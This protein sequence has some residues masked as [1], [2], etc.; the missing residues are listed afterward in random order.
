MHLAIVLGWSKLVDEIIL[1]SISLEQKDTCGRTPCMLAA[2]M[3]H[4]DILRM[5]L[6][7]NAHIN[8][9]DSD[10]KTALMYAVQSYLRYHDYHGCE[11]CMNLLLERNADVNIVDSKGHNAILGQFR[12]WKKPGKDKVL[13]ALINAGCSIS[14]K[15]RPG[16]APLHMAVA[17]LS[18]DL[19]DSFI[20]LGADV[21]QVTGDNKS[22]LCELSRLTS[23]NMPYDKN[24]STEVAKCLLGYGADPDITHP[25][26]V[27]VVY[28][29]LGIVETILDSDGYIN[30]V[31]P[32]YGTVLF[33]AGVVGNHDMAKLALLFKAEI[34]ISN[35]PHKDFPHHPEKADK[36]ALMLL[37]ATGEYYH[38]WNHQTDVFQHQF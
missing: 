22:A 25:L 9:Q 1:C 8:K 17:S 20:A 15:S 19:I 4:V 35:I 26:V 38:F 6:D 10:G 7:N 11:D 30:D 18:M 24:M 36:Y 31:H 5:L 29:R 37:F 2:Q 33:N 3:G 32:N 34:N 14:A 27:A 21:D 28:N 13:V 23:H 12:D 16:N